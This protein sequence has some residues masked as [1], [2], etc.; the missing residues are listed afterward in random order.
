MKKPRYAEKES[1]DTKLKRYST[2]LIKELSIKIDFKIKTWNIGKLSVFELS[3]ENEDTAFKFL[4]KFSGHEI[5]CH[6]ILVLKCKNLDVGQ[7]MQDISSNSSLSLLMKSNIDFN[8]SFM[9]SVACLAVKEGICKFLVE[10]KLINEEDLKGDSLLTMKWAGDILFQNKKVAEV[11]VDSSYIINSSGPVMNYGPIKVALSIKINVNTNPSIDIESSCLK[12]MM[13]SEKEIDCQALNNIVIE[14]IVH[15]FYQLNRSSLHCQLLSL[16]NESMKYTH[17]CVD[18]LDSNDRILSTGIFLGI[19]SYGNA[20]IK[21]SESKAV[22]VTSGKMIKNLQNMEYKFTTD[23]ENSSTMLNTQEASDYTIT[24]DP[25]VMC[26]TADITIQQGEEE[27]LPQQT[28]MEIDLPQNFEEPTMNTIESPLINIQIEY[29]EVS[30]PQEKEEEYE[31][32]E[33]KMTMKCSASNAFSW[34]KSLFCASLL[35]IG[36]AFTYYIYKKRST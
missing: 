31:I 22:E 19:N 2:K 14:N 3:L 26:G 6:Y 8:N 7:G 34:S 25:S 15:R 16:I 13:D 10:N 20:V 4:S 17:E 28:Q 1:A 11:S 30:V 5:P 29:P 12:E 32:E 35:L 18:I 21:T 33:S 9:T 27:A 23:V 36:S 24:P